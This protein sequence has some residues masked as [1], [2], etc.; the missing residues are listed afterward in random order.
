MAVLD[1]GAE[2]S[3]KFI[4]KADILFHSLC[5]IGNNNLEGLDV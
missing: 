2:T 3:W 1:E 4:K 5:L